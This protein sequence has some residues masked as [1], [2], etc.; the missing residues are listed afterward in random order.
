MIHP[1]LHPVKSGT[2]ALPECFDQLHT[3]L[4]EL[5]SWFA[6]EHVPP[7]KATLLCGISSSGRGMAVH[8]I[9]GVLNRQTYRLDPACDAFAMAEIL[10]LLGANA[11]CVLWIDR[12][13][14]THT[15][16]LPWLLDHE[17]SS[18]FVVLTSDEPYKLPVE[19]MRSDVIES[20]WHFDLPNSQQRCELWHAFVPLDGSAGGGYDAVRLAHASAMFSVGEIQA[21]SKRAQRKHPG[22]ELSNNELLD[23]IFA[24]RPLAYEC[25]EQ[26]ARLLDWATLRAKHAMSPRMRQDAESV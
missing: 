25:D 1:F 18:V 16:V 6:N 22:K 2:T 14:E 19:F 11:P 12:P 15:G 23:E 10:A 8:A 4:K 9:T 20:V 5:P 17:R 3:W 13:G 24:I 7:P 26:L 21:A